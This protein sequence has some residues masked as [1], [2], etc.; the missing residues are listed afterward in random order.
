MKNPIR[1]TEI[2]PT[3]RIVS[4]H[5][6]YALF[7]AVLCTVQVVLGTMMSQN[8]ASWMGRTIH[9]AMGRYVLPLLIL[10]LNGSVLIILFDGPSRANLHSTTHF[11][12]T[13]AA[14]FITAWSAMGY[15]FAFTKQYQRHKDCM[16]AV[17]IITIGP[18]TLRTLRWTFQTSHYLIY[19]TF[20]E[21]VN[22]FPYIMATNT[23]LSLA[24][25]GMLINND[26]LSRDQPQ[27][28]MLM[29]GSLGV[30][31]YP[32]LTMVIDFNPCHRVNLPDAL[33]AAE[34][35]GICG[36]FSFLSY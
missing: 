14:I 21:D 7:W 35:C 17:L 34:N 26:R 19:S 32:M 30:V 3:Q 6:M 25:F 13:Q 10:A 4:V 28:I 15:Y 29:I 8:K 2:Q 27:N 5:A 18:A 11:I 12:N 16:M 24:I 20:A 31:M 23:V 9:I 33:L 1:A 22:F 36:L